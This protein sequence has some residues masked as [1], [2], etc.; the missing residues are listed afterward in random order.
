MSYFDFTLIL[1]HKKNYTSFAKPVYF[2]LNVVEFYWKKSSESNVRQLL[3]Q[4]IYQ[5]NKNWAIDLACPGVGHF[6]SSGCLL[7]R[8][9][10]KD[11][12]LIFFIL[13]LF[14]YYIRYILS[15]MS[16]SRPYGG[17]GLVDEPYIMEAAWIIAA[18]Q[19]FF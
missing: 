10:N 9:F 4:T 12:L 5:V 8:F 7:D 6:N 16:R 11:S 13:R 1:P 3:L 18:L 19:K 2:F 17:C 14:I 15:T